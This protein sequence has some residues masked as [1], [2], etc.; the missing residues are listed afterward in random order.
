MRGLVLPVTG[1]ITNRYVKIFVPKPIKLSPK[2]VRFVMI[3]NVTRKQDCGKLFIAFFCEALT[4]K[5]WA[6][7]TSSPLVKYPVPN[8]HDP[9]NSHTRLIVSQLLRCGAAICCISVTFGWSNCRGRFLAPSRNTPFAGPSPASLP[10]RLPPPLP[11]V[12]GVPAA[13][14]ERSALCFR[15]CSSAV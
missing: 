3:A 4:A 10:R 1:K 9:A 13:G 11:T 6:I 2:S 15:G 8:A 14:F 7:S 12:F 5:I